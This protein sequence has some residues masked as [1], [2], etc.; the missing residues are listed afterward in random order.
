MCIM[1]IINKMTTSDQKNRTENLFS[2]QRPPAQ[3]T[4]HIHETI[5]NASCSQSITDTYDYIVDNKYIG[6]TIVVNMCT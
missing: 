6:I 3:N 5:T 4:K 2:K 1:S